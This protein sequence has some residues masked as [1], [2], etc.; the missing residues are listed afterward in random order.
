MAHIESTWMAINGCVKNTFIDWFTIK[1]ITWIFWWIIWLITDWH[2][3]LILMIFILYFVDLITWVIK[4]VK[5]KDFQSAKFFVWATKILAYGIFAF[6]WV[7]LDQALHTWS[8][9]LWTVFAFI[10]L[11]DAISILE[12]LTELGYKTPVFLVSFLKVYKKKMEDDFWERKIFSNT[13]N[14]SEQNK[15]I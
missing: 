13:K 4:A 1:A 8:L 7:S 14:F 11:T 3:I 15:K 9:F 10:V 6:I 2:E 12:N 5:N